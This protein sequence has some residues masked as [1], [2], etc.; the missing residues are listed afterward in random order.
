MAAFSRDSASVNGVAVRRLR[1]P[2]STSRRT[3]SASATP[4]ATWVSIDLDILGLFLSAFIKLV[5]S[6]ASAK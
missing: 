6:S 2:P 5:Y 3:F 4:S 1:T